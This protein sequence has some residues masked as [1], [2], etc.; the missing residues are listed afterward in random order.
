VFDRTLQRA[1]DYFGVPSRQI[2]AVLACVVLLAAT[3]LVTGS[4]L[5]TAV[6]LCVLFAVVRAVRAVRGG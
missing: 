5:A 1:G 2:P 3:S 6:V 4:M